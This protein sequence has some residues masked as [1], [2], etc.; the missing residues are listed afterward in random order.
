[1]ATVAGD[2][3]APEETSPA[4]R[5]PPTHEHAVQLRS[6]QRT[7]RGSVRALTL[8]ATPHTAVRG[9][10]GARTSPRADR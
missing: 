1:V 9:W 7:R 3:A 8:H 6:G 5:L 2:L 4:L 10:V